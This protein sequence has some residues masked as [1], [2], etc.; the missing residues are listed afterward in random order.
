MGV[1]IGEWAKTVVVF[2]ASRIPQRELD[3]LAVDLHIGDV[4]LE[5]GGDIDLGCGKAC[6]DANIATTVNNRVSHMLRTTMYAPLGMFLSRT[7]SAD[8]SSG[9]ESSVGQIRMV[10]STTDGNGHTFPQAPSPTITSFLRIS[11][12]W[13]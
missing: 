1:G 11:D 9:G 7:Q 12:I 6:A 13:N 4:V 3:V 10:A 8:K 5:H 2:L